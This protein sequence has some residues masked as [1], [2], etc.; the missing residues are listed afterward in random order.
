LFNVHRGEEGLKLK[1]N[2]YDIYTVENLMNVECEDVD[3]ILHL[4]HY[5]I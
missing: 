1:W 2:Q 4:Y 3:E 5:G